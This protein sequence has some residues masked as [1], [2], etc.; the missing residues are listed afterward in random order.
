MDPLTWLTI[1]TTKI[2]FMDS[3][4]HWLTK[5]LSKIR[6]FSKTSRKCKL[7]VKLLYKSINSKVR[8]R[9]K[10][11]S[12]CPLRKRINHRLR[13]NLLLQRSSINK[14][15]NQLLKKF[16]QHFPRYNKAKAQFF[17]TLTLSNRKSSLNLNPRI[18]REAL[19]WWNLLT[20]I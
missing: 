13:K 9:T 14:L 7:I 10:K 18:W 4:Y 16:L 20:K 1:L 2:L 8:K 6:I 17:K 3:R 15:Q 5:K 12:N 11:L 19:K